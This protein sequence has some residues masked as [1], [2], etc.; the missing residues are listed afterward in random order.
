MMDYR[1]NLVGCDHAYWTNNNDEIPGRVKDLDAIYYY[2]QCNRSLNEEPGQMS[3]RCPSSCDANNGKSYIAINITFKLDYTS[4]SKLTAIEIKL[5]GLYGG[6]HGGKTWCVLY[7]YGKGNVTYNDAKNHIFYY[8]GF[9]GLVPGYEYEV[10]IRGLPTARV[11]ESTWS[12]FKIKTRPCWKPFIMW[13]LTPFALNFT[14]ILNSQDDYKD[15]IDE[16]Y[17]AVYSSGSSS[18]IHGEQIIQNKYNTTQVVFGCLEP[19]NYTLEIRAR[20]T[21]E[22]CLPY[23]KENLTIF[24]AKPLVTA[25]P[26]NITLYTEFGGNVS[27]TWPIPS[28]SSPCPSLA[29]IKSKQSH[30][31]GDVFQEGTITEVRYD[32]SQYYQDDNATCSFFIHIL[33]DTDPPVVTCANI[34]LPT[35]SPNTFNGL[36]DGESYTYADANPDPKGITYNVTQGITGDLFP[37]GYTPVTLVAKDTFGNKATCV[38]YVEN[39]LTELPVNCP[40]LDHTVT[41][42]PG[43]DTYTFH[44]SFG[45]HNITKSVAG[46][47]YHGDTV[48]MEITLGGSPVGTSVSIGAHE[49]VV[50]IHDDVLNKTCRGLYTVTEHFPTGSVPIAIIV[51]SVLGIALAILAL[52]TINNYWP[53]EPG[54]SRLGTCLEKLRNLTATDPENKLPGDYTS[55]AFYSRV[56]QGKTIEPGIDL[57]ILVNAPEP[58]EYSS[59]TN[60]NDIK[61]RNWVYDQHDS[62]FTDREEEQIREKSQSQVMHK[63]EIHPDSPGSQHD[64]GFDTGTGVVY[65]Q[66]HLQHS[67]E[68]GDVDERGESSGGTSWPLLQHSDTSVADS[69]TL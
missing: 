28:A 38:F 59:A 27:V 54:E 66:E 24:S 5:F 25:C 15:S 52:F 33:S 20:G 48:V 45:E 60:I 32:F 47:I 58:S 68:D 26:D 64:T 36:I 62:G 44:P 53:K 22:S 12:K 23:V 29:P 41:T 57:N 61:V 63:C 14:L 1:K 17:I 11:D 65:S 49:I 21:C 37:Q 39:V 7:E 50:I 6:F 43:K 46:Y 31:P 8:D 9:I 3:D 55:E 35:E 30:H 40:S 42:D 51:G 10:G 16:Y 67:T 34:T 2:T 18:S 4:A 19:H 13:H 56:D 69:D